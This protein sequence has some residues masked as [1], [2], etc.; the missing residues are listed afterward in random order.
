MWVY[1]KPSEADFKPDRN[2]LEKIC[3]KIETTAY[4]YQSAKRSIKQL[5]LY[6]TKG[7]LAYINFADAYES[8]FWDY[9]RKLGG[10]DPKE[11]PPKF[12]GGSDLVAGGIIGSV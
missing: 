6:N 3:A 8:M 2:T 4:D 11:E 5:G 7:R 10:F 9:Q 1:N 12:V